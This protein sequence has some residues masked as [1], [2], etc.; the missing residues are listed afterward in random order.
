MTVS[1]RRNG[2]TLIELLVVIAIIAILVGLLLPAVQKARQSAARSQ[3]A[4]NI[5]QMSLALQN[6][7]DSHG[8]LPSAAGYFPG[9]NATG[10]APMP[11]PH[12]TLQYYL[13]P[14]LEHQGVFN[15]TANFSYTSNDIIKTYQ[16]PGDPSLP[17]TGLHDFNRGANSYACNYYVFG[18]VDGG[19][20]T[21]PNTFH[22][23]TSNTI[24]FFERYSECQANQWIWGEDGT[25]SLVPTWP[26]PY[27]S[28]TYSMTAPPAPVPPAVGPIPL[29]QQAPTPANCDPTLLQTPYSGG[30]VVGLGDGSVRIVSSSVSQYSWQLA[31]TPA[32]GAVLDSSW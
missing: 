6:C 15:N 18:I 25:I 14:Y 32:D 21:I 24:V 19:R 20:A 17:T 4:N 7:N 23:G 28:A 22:D 26:N 27:M 13:L 8:K 16:S 31:I 1:N 29:P 3:D 12:G 30:I 5:K 9:V 10:V 2:F 11:S